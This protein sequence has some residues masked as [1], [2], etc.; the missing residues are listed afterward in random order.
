[1]ATVTSAGIEGT[2]PVEESPLEL[3][4]NNQ[5]FFLAD[6]E[7]MGVVAE[8]IRNDMGDSLGIM[9]YDDVTRQVHKFRA[10][11][12]VVRPD[13]NV[14]VLPSWFKKSREILRNIE[15]ME[16][17][18][19]A[20]NKARK[21]GVR[22][23]EDDAAAATSDA[24]AEVQRYIDEAVILRSQIIGKLHGLFQKQTATESQLRDLA[25]PGM[26]DRTPVEDRKLQIATLKRS[27]RLNDQTVNAMR[28]F[29]VRM[30]TSYLFPKDPRYRALFKVEEFQAVEEAAPVPDEGI[31]EF[32]TF[33]D[34]DEG[35]DEFETF[36]EFPEATPFEDV[37]DFE[38]IPEMEEI[39]VGAPPPGPEVPHPPPA[40]AVP[41]DPA[42]GVAPAAPS[43]HDVEALPDADEAT[44]DQPSLMAVGAPGWAPPQPNQPYAAP[45]GVGVAPPPPPGAAAAVP[46]PPMPS[47]DEFEVTGQRKINGEAAEPE[48]VAKKAG[49]LGRLRRGKE[50]KTQAPVPAVAASAA[51]GG[52]VAQGATQPV[53]EF[54]P[55]EEFETFE[56]VPE[57]P[58][59]PP[60]FDMPPPPALPPPP[61]YTPHAEALAIDSFQEVPSETEFDPVVPAAAEVPVATP[62]PP[63][64]PVQQQP[65][66]APQP[67]P[68]TAPPPV[69]V[70]VPTPAPAP[71]PPP[72]PAPAP[73]PVPTPAPMAEETFETFEDVAEEV[74]AF[75]EVVEEPG[76]Q[77]LDAEKDIDAILAMALGKTPPP[78][79]RPTAE[80][81]V[82]EDMGSPMHSLLAKTKYRRGD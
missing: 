67:V 12:L 55:V 27:H 58:A 14:T 23:S 42:V 13:G 19:P 44:V 6:T 32:E 34:V 60:G 36:E 16:Q 8:V 69:P 79:S 75:D 7:P 21:K 52:A 66:V 82:R 40:P 43:F 11:Q 10:S 50:K 2:I 61:S 48:P 46:P 29:L 78:K 81:G 18:V 72:G 76:E 47:M 4:I 64:P 39:P 25:S 37:D 17:A 56:D 65:Q 74:P 49:L 20:I 24:T 54:A 51:P 57:T 73:A 1:L 53:E 68:A 45:A 38:D 15:P 71:A 77:P 9:V 22:L 26:F 5:A 30:D 80:P 35:V 3:S 62:I 41:A 33:E 59:V 28:D 63:P 31:D 70:H